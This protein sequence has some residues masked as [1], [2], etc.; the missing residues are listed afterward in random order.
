M[1]DNG[2]PSVPGESTSLRIKPAT[3]EHV[4]IA[5][6]KGWRD[7]LAAPFQGIF[8]G[9]VYA[10]GG[11]LI[12]LL[13][14]RLRMSYLAY[15]LAAGFVMLAPFVATGLYEVSRRHENG[16]PMS[17]VAVLSAV[18]RQ[19]GREMG[20]MAFVTLF[21]F[22]IWMYQTRLLLAFFLGFGNFASLQEFVM[23]V[24]TTREGLAFLAIGHVV[25][26]ALSA[27]LFSI[28]VISFPLLLDRDVDFITAMVTS[29]HAVALSPIVMLGWAA[30]IVIAMIL[31]MLPAFLGLLVVMPVL[32]H[33]SWHLYRALIE[34]EAPA[35]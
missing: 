24:L 13:L 4:R 18:W 20:W 31:A 2:A 19:G 32:G 22:I 23:V 15:P 34:T 26:A 25:G 1:A 21:F 5:L 35:A 10:G 6:T 17:F 16:L 33:A 3:V 9:A 27:I 12:L 30:V 7:F 11:L 14:T 8:F 28:T 29:V